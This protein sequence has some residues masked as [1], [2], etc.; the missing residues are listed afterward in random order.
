MHSE[1][2]TVTGRSVANRTVQAVDFYD[3][4][5]ISDWATVRG[6]AAITYT[7]NC[8]ATVLRRG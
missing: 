2:C 6:Q 4:Y 5:E 1:K 7:G 3:A 8:T